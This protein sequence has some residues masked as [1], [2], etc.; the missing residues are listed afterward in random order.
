VGFRDR[1]RRTY[2]RRAFWR[3][4]ARLLAR[5]RRHKWGRV[6][7]IH[8]RDVC[9]GIHGR[10]AAVS[11]CNFSLWNA[12]SPLRARHFRDS[13]LFS[14]LPVLLSFLPLTGDP[15]GGDVRSLDLIEFKRD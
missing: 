12:Q 6:R 11:A 15:Q 2:H 13:L 3:L 9:I 10:L 4:F 14:L 1:R 8:P 7:G 5:D